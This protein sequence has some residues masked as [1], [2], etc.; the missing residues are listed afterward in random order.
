MKHIADEALR[1][2]PSAEDKL[3]SMCLVF[4][5]DV[6]PG[7]S[8]DENVNK[9]VSLFSLRHCNRLSEGQFRYF[10]DEKHSRFELSFSSPNCANWPDFL[11]EDKLQPKLYLARSID[12]RPKSSAHCGYEVSASVKNRT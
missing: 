7:R 11:L 6:A 3:M 2:R 8:G 9:Q 5:V 1:A 10:I 12:G 4:I